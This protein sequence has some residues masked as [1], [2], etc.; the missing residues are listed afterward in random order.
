MA[1][2]DSNKI[3]TA[4]RDFITS[5]DIFTAADHQL[6]R[7]KSQATSA[8][9]KASQNIAR[10]S[11]NQNMPFSASRDLVW[12][13]LLHLHLLH[14]H[15]DRLSS[16]SSKAVVLGNVASEGGKAEATQTNEK[17]NKVDLDTELDGLKSISESQNRVVQVDWA[18]AS[19]FSGYPCIIL[20]LSWLLEHLEP[21]SDSPI[22]SPA[23]RPPLPLNLINLINQLL[24]SQLKI[25]LPP[26]DSESKILPSQLHPRQN[27]LGPGA[28]SSKAQEDQTFSIGVEDDRYI[29]T[30]WLGDSNKA[31]KAKFISTAVHQQSFV[32]LPEAYILM[33]GNWTV[34]LETIIRS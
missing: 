17:I 15:T 3:L 21:Y 11:S 22:P 26:L 29:T 27:T 5:V 23:L 24:C 18:G 4:A 19:V 34:Y 1:L 13:T 9:E 16:S 14:D 28:S 33:V 6:N 30:N 2:E 31:Q 8:L 25:D 10:E 7:Q 20:L 12:A 32:C